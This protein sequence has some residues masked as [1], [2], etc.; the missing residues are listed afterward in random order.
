MPKPTVFISTLNVIKGCPPHHYH[1]G[2]LRQNQMAA[3]AS[4]VLPV[5]CVRDKDS[6]PSL[7]ARTSCVLCGTQ[8]KMKTWDPLFQKCYKQQ[9]QSIKPS[10]GGLF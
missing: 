7:P 6:F 2:S 5:L 3:G 8:C 1:S 9:Q 10:W 4:P